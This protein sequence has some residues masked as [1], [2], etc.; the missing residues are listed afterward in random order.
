MNVAQRQHTPR[1][2]SQKFNC[3]VG[4]L[5]N[6]NKKRIPLDFQ[7][8]TNINLQAREFVQSL[9]QPKNYKQRWKTNTRMHPFGEGVQPFTGRWLHCQVENHV[10]T[11]KS[12]FSKLHHQNGSN[13]YQ[14]FFTSRYTWY[15]LRSRN[16]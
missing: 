5:I 4:V 14:I 2:P 7:P 15:L 9:G 16:W 6:T 10:R 3:K 1:K 8:T 12:T 11:K 13:F